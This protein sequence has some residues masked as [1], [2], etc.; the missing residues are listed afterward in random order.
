LNTN[1]NTNDPAINPGK[2]S[3]MILV[4]L[5]AATAAMHVA[6]AATAQ[7][8]IFRDELYYI[9]CANHPDIGYVDHPPLSIWLLSAWKWIFGDSLLSIRVLP[10]LASGMTTFIV[11]RLAEGLG[12]GRFAVIL[13]CVSVMFA[14]IFLAFFS[15]FSMNA[16]DL[17][18]WACAFLLL[19]KMGRRGDPRHWYMLGLVIGLGAL[20][21][22]SMLWLGAG[23]LAGTLLTEHRSVLRTRAPWIGGI[24]AAMIFLPFIVWNATHD[25]A[26]LEFIR[27]A[28]GE[29]YAS[30]NPLTFISGI[31]M[32]MNPVAAPLWL[33]GFWFLLTRRE[34]RLIGIAVLAVLAILMANVHTKPE[35]FAA[36]ATVLLGAGSVQI[37]RWFR[38]RVGVWLRTAYAVTLVIT[39]LVLIPLTIDV[40]PVNAFVRY[41]AALG[42][43]PESNEGHRLNDLPQF[44]ADRFGWENMAGVVAGVYA[45]LPDSEKSRCLIY[46]RNYGE[47]G[48]V[49]YFGRVYNLPP[50][51][52]R[53]NSYWFWSFDHLRQDATMIVI[54][55]DRDDLLETFEE[56][57][58]AGVISSELAMPYENDLPVMVCRKLRVPIIEAWLSRHVFI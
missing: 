41:Q 5:S 54:G 31:F 49:D 52:S 10:A 50:A 47:A 8:G 1:E 39:G 32:I 11:G 25:F 28:S 46:G 13:A 55:V 33:A 16:F 9:A 37:E 56:V 6:F 19:V 34:N 4:A 40:L 21:K 20:N 14:P 24:L 29:K 2:N 38:G 58:P 43:A 36:A 17:L 51:I 22:I 12:G 15:I 42:Q 45:S 18:L 48:A 57:E 30:Q 3:L 23:V 35:Y 7:F 26:H 44:Y 27:N 53:H